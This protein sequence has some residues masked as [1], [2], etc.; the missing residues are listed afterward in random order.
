[1]SSDG[2][3]AEPNDQILT[4]PRDQIRVGAAGSRELRNLEP[5]FFVYRDTPETIAKY[6]TPEG[7]KEF[8]KI[9]QSAIEKSLVYAIER[10]MRSMP[11]G[12]TA[13]AGLSFAVAGR[14]RAALQGIYNVLVKGEE[15][16]RRFPAGTYV[17]VI[18]F[19]IPTQAGFR[20]DRVERVGNTI[21]IRYMLPSHGLTVVSWKLALIPLDELPPGE[22]H[23][24]T[25]RS[26]EMEKNFNQRGYS[27]YEPGVERRIVSGPFSYTVTEQD[28]P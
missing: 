1:M 24:E 7:L 10:A 17:S 16:Q 15:P 23:V 6:S 11:K 14:D 2:T 8:E 12:K 5:E 21:H 13:K 27:S 20:L 9:Y 4:I 26:S 18:F 25:H 22:Y 19:T 28:P 3:A